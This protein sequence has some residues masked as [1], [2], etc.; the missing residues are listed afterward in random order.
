MHEYNDMA[1]YYDL[2]Y[3][4]KSYDKEVGFL[5]NII[6]NRKTILD[7]GCG[8]GIHMHLLEQ[9]GYF[10]DG[11]DLNN[12]MLEIARNRTKGH[13]FKAN[14]LDYKIQ[15]K[16]DA[17]ISMFA[18]FNHLNNYKEFEQG[19]LHSLEYLN[20]NGILIIDL[21]N[22]RKSGEKS[23][24]YNEYIRIMKWNFNL[25]TFKETTDIT[26][27]IGNDKYTDSHIFLIYE[28]NKIKTILDKYDLKYNLLE[29]YTFNEAN[30]NS[31]N[32]NIVIYKE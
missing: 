13:L 27:I 8:T 10:V 31:K 3:N 28:I 30:D 19:I 15:S 22:S 5:I 4:T 23:T 16:Y 17:I 25:N 32:I 14:L 18:V 21:H 26:Y 12:E 24:T 20:K 11:I 1:K 2:F 6:G 9:K 7:V 29:N